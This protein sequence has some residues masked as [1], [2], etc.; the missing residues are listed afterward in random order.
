M[1]S[2]LEFDLL[3]AFPE[4]K[5]A[6]FF[7]NERF[8]LSERGKKE[9]YQKALE[10]IGTPKAVRIKQCHGD[11]LLEIKKKSPFLDFYKNFDGMITREKG[12]SLVVR[13]ADCQAALFYDPQKKAIANV[14]CGWR[15]SVKN[16]YR[17]T[18]QMMHCLYQSDPKDLRV[19]ISPSL[20]PEKAE[21]LHYREAFPK[22]FWPYQ[23]EKN[24]FDFWA[25]SSMQLK[26]EGV[27]E[28]NIELARL[29][30]YSHPENFFSY[31]REGR[32]GSQA[33]IIALTPFSS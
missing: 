31:R 19:C 10:I 20:G 28:K 16:I 27:L 25:I 22:E 29:C 24:H 8:D 11:D 9:H 2:Y 23:L 13:H 6:S 5:H 15:G 17:K 21:Y 30:T 32:S 7:K 12:V 26:R 14:H 3:S 4:V 33:T 18:I 1:I